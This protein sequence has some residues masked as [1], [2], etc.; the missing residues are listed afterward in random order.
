MQSQCCDL[1]KFY[2]IFCNEHHACCTHANSM[3]LAERDFANGKVHV[4]NG[5]W[6]EKQWKNHICPAQLAFALRV[7]CEC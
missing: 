6:E 7:H 1:P 2:E 4:A 3:W 5:V